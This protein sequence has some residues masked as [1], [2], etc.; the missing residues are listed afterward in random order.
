MAPPLSSPVSFHVA[1]VKIERKETAENPS[2]TL[3]HHALVAIEI[4]GTYILK[5][6]FSR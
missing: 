2:P 1:H 6:L 3:Q 4:D 5:H